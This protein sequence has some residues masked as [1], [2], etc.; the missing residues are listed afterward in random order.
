MCWVALNSGRASVFDGNQR[1][2]GVGTIVRTGGMY[3]TF[4]HSGPWVIIPRSVLLES[5]VR[6]IECRDHGTRLC[7]IFTALRGETT[8][9]LADQNLVGTKR[10]KSGPK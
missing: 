8:H 5:G 1:P 4:H 2:A 7:S 6:S 9:G 3:D 10:A